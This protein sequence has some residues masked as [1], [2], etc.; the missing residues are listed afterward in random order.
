MT[1][2]YRLGP[3]PLK[4]VR[5]GKKMV[6]YDT[7]FVISEVSA[8]HHSFLVK[9]QYMVGGGGQRLPPGCKVTKDLGAAP[10]VA[11]GTYI[12]AKAVVGFNQQPWTH[13]FHTRARSPAEDPSIL[14]RF[15]AVRAFDI[16]RNDDPSGMSSL[17]FDTTSPA[18]SVSTLASTPNTVS[19]LGHSHRVFSRAL[20]T[21][22][23]DNDAIRFEVP[24][25]LFE[26]DFAVD[27]CNLA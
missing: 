24:V 6:N 22:I 23:I 27:I 14:T 12:V 19:T 18:S 25:V 21:S 16:L 13:M 2:D 4:A 15:P 1:G 3:A 9:C 26:D 20:P 11:S 17:V 10:N 5:E 8:R 7:S